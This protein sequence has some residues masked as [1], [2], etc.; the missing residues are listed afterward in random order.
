MRIGCNFLMKEVADALRF[1]TEAVTARGS[2]KP[3]GG[4]GR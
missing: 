4:R 2:G 1:Y 3:S